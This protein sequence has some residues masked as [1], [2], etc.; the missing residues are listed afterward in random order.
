MKM[1]ELFLRQKKGVSFEF[2]P[3]KTKAGEDHLTDVIASLG[4]WKPAFISVTYAAG[5][6]NSK[7]TPIVIERIKQEN[8]LTLMPHLSCLGQDREELAAAL[9][10]YRQLGIQ[11][12]M[13][14]RGD[15]ARAPE[16]GMAG[17]EFH[18]AAEL[19]RLAASF[20]A[21]SVAVA[22]YPEGH[23]ES[24]DID[25]DIKYAKEKID[26]GADFAITQMFFDNRFFYDFMEKAG[27]AGIR[28]PVI[29]GIMPVTDIAKIKTLSRI[30]GAT[31]PPALVERME[32]ARS[33]EEARH[34]GIDFVT[35]QC[36][37]LLR[38]G[39]DYLHFFTMNQTEAVTEVLR[40]LDLPH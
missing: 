21:F 37:D 40:N 3:P 7:N 13:A 5:G 33:P 22:V 28:I 2:F 35:R 30:C 20:E 6:S 11:N 26:A 27:R 4:V 23:A 14:L 18:H 17:G 31:L 12:I 32:N 39:A 38:N 36:E 24:P 29:P 10:K 16:K 19:V 25:A 8:S 34:R 9:S 1:R 15:S